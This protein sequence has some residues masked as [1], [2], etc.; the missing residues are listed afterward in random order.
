LVWIS[1]IPFLPNVP[2]SFQASPKWISHFTISKPAISHLFSLELECIAMT[3][4]VFIYTYFVVQWKSL[5]ATLAG[6]LRR[7][8]AAE[9]TIRQ[10]EAEIEQLNRL[11]CSLIIIME[12][13]LKYI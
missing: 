5:E 4:F 10:L 2:E 1:P 3:P 6:A 11:V 8:R 7:E 12:Q 9:T 13:T